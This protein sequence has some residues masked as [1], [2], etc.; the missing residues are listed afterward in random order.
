MGVQVDMTDPWEEGG[1]G[2][3]NKRLEVKHNQNMVDKE[4]QIYNNDPNLF[5]FDDEVQNLNL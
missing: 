1:G 3:G 4:T 2:A 5:V